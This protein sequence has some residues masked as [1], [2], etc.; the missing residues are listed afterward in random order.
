[1]C[2]SGCHSARGATRQIG[3]R[4]GVAAVEAAVTLP[5]IVVLLLGMLEV[6]RL[7][8]VQEILNNAVREG[9]RQAAGGVSTSSKVQQAV[10]N[11]LSRAG[12]TTT[13]ATVTVTDLTSPSTDVSTA[14]QNHRLQVSVT[15]PLKNVRW[16]SSTLVTSASTQLTA[17]AIWFSAQSQSY[18]SSFTVPA[19][20]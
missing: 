20:Y 18:P 9:A 7:I 5:I 12:L 15:M 2:L 17:Q 1:M 4:R 11:Y 19:G 8:E 10:L 13:G 3:R 16:S 14:A 6:G